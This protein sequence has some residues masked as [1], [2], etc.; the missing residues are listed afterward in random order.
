MKHEKVDEE[1]DEDE[2]EVI[3]RVMEEVPELVLVQEVPVLVMVKVLVLTLVL[4]PSA[5]LLSWSCAIPG[6]VEP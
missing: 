4:M 5:R 6:E 3:P 1:G 2:R